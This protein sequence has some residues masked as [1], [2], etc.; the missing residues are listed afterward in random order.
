MFC[1]VNVNRAIIERMCEIEYIFIVI[2]R[3][4]RVY[5]IFK[6]LNIKTV[7]NLLLLE[8]EKG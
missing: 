8:L 4:I 3:I 6:V 7:Q 2:H 5:E 1:S